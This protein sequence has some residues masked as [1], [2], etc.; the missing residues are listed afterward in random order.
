MFKI[1]AKHSYKEE[2]NLEV[3]NIE[4]GIMLLTTIVCHD[5]GEGIIVD[6]KNR[7]IKTVKEVFVNTIIDEEGIEYTITNADSGDKYNMGLMSLS[8]LIK[9]EKIISS[10]FNSLDKNKIHSNILSIINSLVG[11]LSISI[12]MYSEK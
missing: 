5:Y 4:L 2:I 1:K 6:S 11:T 3:E 12:E 10:Y 7:I 9:W 8:E